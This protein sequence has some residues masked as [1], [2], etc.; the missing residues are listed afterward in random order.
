MRNKNYYWD[1]FIESW[2]IKYVKKSQ[3]P[4]KPPK[5]LLSKTG[6]KKH[7]TYNH[8]IIKH[9]S[10]S[11]TAL[12]DYF[13]DEIMQPPPTLKTIIKKCRHALKT[14]EKNHSCPISITCKV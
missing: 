3:E 2:N 5:T 10:E 11:A 12:S 6:M 13:I 9:K 8:K 4:S 7:I 1:Q 14:L